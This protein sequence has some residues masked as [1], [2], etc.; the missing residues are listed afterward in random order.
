[1][2]LKICHLYPDV[3]DLYGDVGNLIAM[4]KRLEWRGIGCS[5]TELCMGEELRPELFDLIFI[6][7]GREEEQLR[8]LPDLHALKAAALKQ[9]V[10]AGVTVLAIGGGFELLGKSYTAFDGSVHDFAGVLDME[11]RAERE[12]FTGNYAFTVP[13]VGPV[14]AF[15]NHCGRTY[16]GPGSEPLGKL[17]CGHGNNGSDG[18]E[19]LRYK[20]LFGSY[21]H[22]SL[23]P[24]NPRLCDLILKTALEHKYGSAELSPLDDSLENSALEYMLR[25]LGK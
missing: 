20:N 23:L 18:C 19:G 21:G 16:P 2:E 9:A 24:K 1:M 10:D 8:L 13:G 11:V 17:L 4:K 12:R 22:G 15:E 6:G 14:A 3:L 5:L 7:S 25:R